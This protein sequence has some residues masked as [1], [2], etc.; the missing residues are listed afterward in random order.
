MN[1]S[2]IIK[3]IALGTILGATSLSASDSIPKN[4][5]SQLNPVGISQRIQTTLEQKLETFK[6][7]I[8]LFKTRELEYEDFLIQ[9]GD[10]YLNIFEDELPEFNDLISPEKLQSAMVFGN[11]VEKHMQQQL[12]YDAP[13]INDILR[14]FAF[15]NIDEDKLYE[16]LF[17]VSN[18]AGTTNLSEIIHRNAQALG[19]IAEITDDFELKNN[20]AERLKEEFKELIIKPIGNLP[21]KNKRAYFD[22][23]IHVWGEVSE[24]IDNSKDEE[25]YY[26]SSSLKY[27]LLRMVSEIGDRINES[28][29]E[30][31]FQQYLIS[32]ANNLN[33]HK[34][35]LLKKSISKK[36]KSFEYQYMS[37]GN[38]NMSILFDHE[39]NN[40]RFEVGKTLG[41]QKKSDRLII[42]LP[43]DT[44]SVS[45]DKIMALVESTDQWAHRIQSSEKDLDKEFQ[46]D[47]ERKVFKIK[48]S[49]AL[50]YIHPKRFESAAYQIIVIRDPAASKVSSEQNGPFIKLTVPEYDPAKDAALIKSQVEAQSFWTDLRPLFQTQL[51]KDLHNEARETNAGGYGRFGEISE[52]INPE[53]RFANETKVVNNILGIL[54]ETNLGERMHLLW[55]FFQGQ[56]V[57]HKRFKSLNEITS[58]DNLDFINQYCLNNITNVTLHS[59][60]YT[61]Y[62][63]F[64]VDWSNIA[65]DVEPEVQQ[66]PMRHFLDQV[67]TLDFNPE[68]LYHIGEVLAILKANSGE[69]YGQYFDDVV[70]QFESQ[71]FPESGDYGPIGLDQLSTMTEVLE[72][73]FHQSGNMF[74]KEN[75]PGFAKGYHYSRFEYGKNSIEFSGNVRINATDG[76]NIFDDLFESGYQVIQDYLFDIQ[77]NLEKRS[78]F[79]EDLTEQE[80]AQAET[81]FNKYCRTLTMNLEST[82]GIMDDVRDIAELTSKTNFGSPDDV[83]NYFSNLTERLTNKISNIVKTEAYRAEMFEGQVMKPFEIKSIKGKVPMQRIMLKDSTDI[84]YM[85]VFDMA[86][87]NFDAEMLG[88]NTDLNQW[89]TERVIKER[90]DMIVETVGVYA[91]NV[92][93]GPAWSMGVTNEEGEREVLNSFWSRKVDGVLMIDEYQ[94]IKIAHR[95]EVARTATQRKAFNEAFQRGEFDNYAQAQMLIYNGSLMHEGKPLISPTNTY[96]DRKRIIGLTNE[97]Q[98]AVIKLTENVTFYET[99]VILQQIGIQ[100]ALNMDKVGGVHDH[101]VDKTGKHVYD[102][103]GGSMNYVSKFVVSLDK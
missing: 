42:T 62:L 34:F 25:Y 50:E 15:Q 33:S 72:L 67:P 91:D 35:G 22:K 83:A 26:E 53:Y 44:E 68:N 59:Q 40:I 49:Y 66:A 80:T 27:E 103:Q 86:S 48:N 95:N 10:A 43:E 36:V 38:G 89:S 47:L 18:N 24:A 8:Q 45:Y 54:D 81:I 60:E 5:F 102:N 77:M 65:R 63:Q 61:D 100:S 17:D 99:A 90:P 55:S 28:G 2:H 57:D 88:V 30:Q 76:R 79:L 87:G 98:L 101:H 56:G 37:L 32:Q 85:Y 96:R 41:I 73:A 74:L 16:S 29:S 1:L 75:F 9:A 84:G 71:L 69:M 12:G 52:E 92:S 20:Y 94:N 39:Y 3:T 6:N 14:S 70:M 51:I 46:Q 31:E 4:N 19:A 64:M 11:K 23:Y 82:S 13:K 78:A 58:I 21:K 93:R 97:G 7:S